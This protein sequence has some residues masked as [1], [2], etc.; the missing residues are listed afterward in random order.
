MSSA[1]ATPGRPASKFSPPDSS[2]NPR[3]IVLGATPV[4]VATAAIP[5]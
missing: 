1:A 2:S 3:P 4:V 5:P